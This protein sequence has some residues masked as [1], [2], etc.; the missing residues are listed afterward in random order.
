[1]V[2]KIFARFIFA[3]AQLS[4]VFSGLHYIMSMS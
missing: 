1:M 2:V 3:I 4:C